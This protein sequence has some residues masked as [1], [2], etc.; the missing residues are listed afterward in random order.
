MPSTIDP[1]VQTYLTSSSVPLASRQQVAN[2]LDSGKVDEATVAKLAQQKYPNLFQ[3]TPLVQQPTQPTTPTQPQ[4]S[5]ANWLDQWS[6]KNGLNQWAQKI[7]NPQPQATQPTQQPPAPEP[8]PGGFQD[9]G[10]QF[11]GPKMQPFQD[12]GTQFPGPVGSSLG[13]AVN[14]VGQGATNV[15]NAALNFN[16]ASPKIDTSTNPVIQ[17]AAD[18]AGNALKGELSGIQQAGQG[19]SDVAQGTS[20]LLNPNST[21][22]QQSQGAIQAG[23]GLINTA[24][25]VEGAA[26]AIPSAVTQ[27][28]P[29]ASQALK[30][31]MDLVNG[32]GQ[33]GSDSFKGVLNYVGIQLSPQQNQ[34]ID[35]GFK[36]LAQLKSIQMAQDVAQT[37]GY[38]QMMSKASDLAQS[39]PMGLVPGTNVPV[40]NLQFYESLA[41]QYGQQPLAGRIGAPI[42]EGAGDVAKGALNMALAPVNAVA[43]SVDS[44][45]NPESSL[46]GPGAEAKPPTEVPPEVTV[47][48]NPVMKKNVEDLTKVVNGNTK[49]RKIVLSAEKQGFDPVSDLAQTDLLKGAVDKTGRITTLGD[50][51]AVDQLNQSIK[52]YEDVVSK[53]LT[54]EA[55]NVPLS[56]VGDAMTQDILN[57][58]L[59]GANLQAALNTVSREVAGLKLEAV[60]M[61]GNPWTEQSDGPP[62]IPVKVLHEAKID[63]YNNIDYT[64]PDSAKVDKIL[65][66]TDKTLVE[67]NSTADISSLNNELA[68]LY[69]VRSLLEALDGKTV[70]G[71]KL[72]LYFAKTIG[73]IGGATI[74]GNLG[75]IA[76]ARLAAAAQSSL[77]SN[78]FSGGTNVPVPQVSDE[79]IEAANPGGS[80]AG[81]GA[82]LKPGSSIGGIQYD[83]NTNYQVEKPN[84][85][86]AP[87]TMTEAAGQGAIT[88]SE[89]P[90][91][92]NSPVYDPEKNYQVENGTEDN[93]PPKKI[94]KSKK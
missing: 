84:D 26:L 63:L 80:G 92:L 13:N 87:T 25:G 69:S 72:G 24:G 51:G 4:Q 66:N 47:E 60:D 23:G 40:T 1:V 79:L 36:Q 6:Q 18:V 56:G 45:V 42:A 50:G 71:G 33:L 19:V 67:D 77:M 73:A 22:D 52:P 65:A 74:G 83:P 64:N 89:T 30:P 86:P 8:L 28:I 14:A 82:E 94:I 70:E 29:G 20:A 7:Q 15:V 17:G 3:T 39:D 57:S 62:Q 88:P 21:P 54:D 46:E 38:H 85:V 78:T 5:T 61:D 48:N 91:N 43:N 34:L 37:T 11:P 35:Q 93:N 12:P 90:N 31:V 58:G 41:G 75:A 49:V 81:P 53:I 55:K 76:G 10:T 44:L 2:D 32:T 16:P 27:A 68:R 59:H 9:P